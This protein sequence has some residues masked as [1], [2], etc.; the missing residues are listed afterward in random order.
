MPGALHV[1]VDELRTSIDVIPRNRR[2]V[3]HCRS[4]VRA[5]LAT[6]ILRQHGFNDV[7]NLTGGW[8]SMMLD[9]GF[10]VAK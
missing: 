2:I 4:G 6:R 10:T 8:V 3:V 5:H 1:P 9:G 7:A